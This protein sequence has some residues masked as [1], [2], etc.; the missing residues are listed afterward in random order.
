MSTSNVGTDEKGQCV[1]IMR[2]G[3]RRDGTPSSVPENDPP[4]TAAGRRDVARVAA[5]IK[6]QFPCASKTIYIIS[7]PFLRTRETAEELQKNGI[8]VSRPITIDN[9]LSEVYGP[10]RIKAGDTHEFE[11]PSVV[12]EGFGTMPSWGETLQMASVRFYDSFINIVSMTENENAARKGH[13]RPRTPL[14]VTHGDALSSIMQQIYPNRI[15]YSADY[16]SFFIAQKNVSSMSGFDVTYTSEVQWIEDQQSSLK[17]NSESVHS[18]EGTS[19]DKKPSEDDERIPQD[20][21]VK[22]VFQTK[23]IIMKEPPDYLKCNEGCKKRCSPVI[24]EVSLQSS[25]DVVNGRSLSG[26]STWAGRR[27][28]PEPQQTSA[29]RT[30]VFLSIFFHIIFI[31]LNVVWGTVLQSKKDRKKSAPFLFSLLAVE[32]GWMAVLYR[33]IYRD[34]L[35]AFFYGTI[36]RMR[37]RDHFISNEVATS[38]TLVREQDEDFLFSTSNCFQMELF[39]PVALWKLIFGLF[40]SYWKAMIGLAA[41]QIFSIIFCSLLFS[42]C[43]WNEFLI[44]QLLIDALVSPLSVVVLVCSFVALLIG[45][46]GDIQI[47]FSINF[48]RMH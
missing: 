43:L 48:I 25:L 22:Y 1:I 13:S 2:H 9:T 40:V 46:L 5:K 34:L 24:S 42:L 35:P 10:I 7:S 44:A 26:Q 30:C 19:D 28:Q 11:N 4:L 38:L 18:E 45:S 37:E 36:A 29:F 16:L 14:L 12:S 20:E 23:R 17:E 21:P 3:E 32:C 15:V 33:S 39:H 27:R 47:A 41:F 31:A 8:G 6:E